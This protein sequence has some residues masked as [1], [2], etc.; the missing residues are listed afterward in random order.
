MNNQNI[1]IYDING[2][3]INDD[4]EDIEKLLDFILEVP[5]KSQI[6][7]KNQEKNIEYFYVDALD[8]NYKFIPDRNIDKKNITKYVPIKINVQKLIEGLNNVAALWRIYIEIRKKYIKNSDLFSAW[9]KLDESNINNAY[10]N[11]IYLDLMINSKSKYANSKFKIITQNYSKNS[12][13][14]CSMTIFLKK[15]RSFIHK[16]KA[17][18]IVSSPDPKIVASLDSKT[19]EKLF[20]FTDHPETTFILGSDTNGL[21]HQL[22]NLFKIKN[23]DEEFYYKLRFIKNAAI[24]EESYI[25]TN[26][27]MKKLQNQ[28]DEIDNNFQHQT[29]IEIERVSN[30]VQSHIYPVI[31]SILGIF[32]AI[33]FAIFGGTNLLNDLFKNIRSTKAS[34]GQALIL[35]SILGFILWGIIDLLFYWIH[36]ISKIKQTKDKENTDYIKEDKIGK[37]KKIFNWIALGFLTIILIIGIYLFC[38]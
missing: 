1:I 34:L 30:H 3:P 8:N 24:M 35:A 36:W 14:K 32:T 13:K 27:K 33:T 26:Q 38:N 31:I 6:S 25:K 12:N 16:K 17:K 9:D 23:Y 2:D 5:V 15:I 10:P 11:E 7:N 4:D 22:N 37:S 21:S 18:N 20:T 29:Q 28:L 19:I